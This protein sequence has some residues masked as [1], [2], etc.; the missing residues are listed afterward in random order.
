MGA[1]ESAGLDDIEQIVE[2]QCA[3]FR[4]DAAAHDPF[5]DLQ[6]PK[7]ESGADL[8][9]MHDNPDCLLLV[10]KHGG[11][12]VAYLAGHITEAPPTRMQATYATLR[13]LYVRPDHRRSGLA[14]QLTE[15]FISWARGRGCAQALVD[16]YAANEPA[17]RLYERH[18]FAAQSVRNVRYL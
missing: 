7:N 6:W 4:E 9:R 18:G 12:P 3:L 14:G 1:V 2:L 15:H 17:R 10:A 5:V 8:T 16:C 11:N 13:S